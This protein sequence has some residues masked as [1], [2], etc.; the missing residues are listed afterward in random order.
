MNSMAEFRNGINE[1]L[2][3]FIPKANSE[4]HQRVIDAMQYSFGNGGK[5]IRPML[6]YASYLL[7][8]KA[9]AAD[10]RYVH[11]FM[12]AMEMIHT[13]SLIH[14][15]LPAM[16]DDDL[17]RGVPTCHKKFD[18]AFAIL[19]GDALLNYAYELT[20]GLTEEALKGLGDD[21]GQTCS[22]LIKSMSILAKSVGVYGMIGGQAAISSLNR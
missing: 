12:S 15:D 19:A 13:S 16:D 4:H 9:D 20:A 6:M 1:I 11:G 22:K 2:M 3:S 8:K 5:R 7:T 18:E 17:R 14:D 21:G 10:E